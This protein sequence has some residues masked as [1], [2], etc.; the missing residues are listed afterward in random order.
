VLSNAAICA[1]L[2]QI[3]VSQILPGGLA[4]C[5]HRINIIIKGQMGRETKASCSGTTISAQHPTADMH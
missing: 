2:R 4:C 3:E 1:E 5:I